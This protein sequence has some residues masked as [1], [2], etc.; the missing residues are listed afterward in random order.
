M[1]RTLGRS[2][3]T[4]VDVP[5]PPTH[6]LPFDMA[7][8]TDSNAIALIHCRTIGSLL[9]ADGILHPLTVGHINKPT[10]ST[11]HPLFRL[12]LAADAGGSRNVHC[13]QSLHSGDGR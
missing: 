11:H 13:S 10:H 2:L 6:R 5:S 3:L 9:E 1:Y 8:T 12:F 7:R 4:S